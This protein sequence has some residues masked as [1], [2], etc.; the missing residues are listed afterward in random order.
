MSMMPRRPWIADEDFLTEEHRALLAREFDTSDPERML[1]LRSTLPAD[2][3]VK[4]ILF[5]YDKR[6]PGGMLNRELRPFIR[7]A[8]CKFKRHWRGFVV[9]LMDDTLALIGEDCGEDQFGI[10]FRLVHDDFNA[11]IAQQKDLRRV[12]KLRAL[13]RPFADEL[14]GLKQAVA[15]A[16]FDD[17]LAGLR[18]FGRL[19]GVLT[20]A[21]QLKGG[22]L[23]YRV[24]ERNLEAEEQNARAHPQYKHHQERIAGAQTDF[25]RR[26]R[27][28]DQK[29]W[30]ASLPRVEKERVVAVGKFVG[31]GIFAMDRDSRLAVDM[32]APR[33]LLTQ[34]IDEFMGNRSDYWTSRRLTAA[35]KDLQ[36]G[37]E[38]LQRA[39]DLLQSL[40]DFTAA[41]NLALIADWSQ[42]EVSVPLPRI[43][44]SVKSSGRQLIDE[45]DR[46][47]LELPS[48]WQ[49]P[50][51]T[52]LV[53]LAEALGDSGDN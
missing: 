37:V 51:L 22:L 4:K 42:R 10:T 2:A 11:Q 3:V 23:T 43:Q 34:R 47:D 7:C 29:V 39:L 50:K 17:Y 24:I 18:R 35:S 26:S 32:R 16:A 41:T 44:Y 6:P 28:E 9:E 40:D 14:Q 31:G 48:T 52:H 15:F 45:E 46:F 13:L 5:K 30:L 12:M 33:A 38:L 36:R 20:E 49:M 8:H 19:Y 21:A 53:A 27:V 25:I 1:D